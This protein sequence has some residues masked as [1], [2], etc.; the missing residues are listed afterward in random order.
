MSKDD[1]FV[2]AYKLLNYLYKCLKSGER[3]DIER[4]SENSKDFPIDAS[5]FS[6]LIEFL[7]KDG[8]IDG[9]TPVPMVGQ[10]QKYKETSSGI[11]ITPK[12]ID[13][14]QENSNMKK[15]ASFLGKGGEIAE[16]II[17]AF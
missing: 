9:L 4:L 8:Y 12:G 6:Y 15:V 11:R 2:L 10:S 13:Y 16:K 7:L 14:L 17:S 5:Y 1:F 3:P